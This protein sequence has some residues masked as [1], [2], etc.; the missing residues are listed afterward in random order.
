MAAEDMEAEDKLVDEDHLARGDG[1]NFSEDE[2]EEI[3]IDVRP[4]EPD[5]KEPSCLLQPKLCLVFVQC[6]EYFPITAWEGFC[7]FKATCDI[8]ISVHSLASG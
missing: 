3:D 2:L 1:I 5:L 7:P 8:Y 4:D 6:C